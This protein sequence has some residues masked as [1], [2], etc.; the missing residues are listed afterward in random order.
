LIAGEMHTLSVARIARLAEAEI[1]DSY[2]P[3]GVGS[4][5]RWSLRVVVCPQLDDELFAL[6]NKLRHQL[7]NV[8]A[9]P[10]T[11]QASGP[12]SNPPAPATPSPRT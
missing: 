3:A 12:P 5:S 2:I 9:H 8:S 11:R 1:S 7:D 10:V 4:F 6:P